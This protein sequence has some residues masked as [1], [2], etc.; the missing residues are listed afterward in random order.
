MLVINLCLLVVERDGNREG[1]KKRD[2]WTGSV[3]PVSGKAIHT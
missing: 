1:D 3:T 2:K